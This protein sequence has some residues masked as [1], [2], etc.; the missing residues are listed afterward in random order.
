M[1]CNLSLC[2]EILTSYKKSNGYHLDALKRDIEIL[3]IGCDGRCQAEYKIIK[4]LIR[5]YNK[6]QFDSN[7]RM[8]F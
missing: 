7:N 1:N 4:K 8:K 6:K 2:S 3:T 5:I